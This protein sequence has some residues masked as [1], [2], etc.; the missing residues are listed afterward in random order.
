MY[1]CDN[2]VK[3]VHVCDDDDYSDDMMTMNLCGLCAMMIFSV[4]MCAI[5]MM[6]TLMIMLTMMMTMNVCLCVCDDYDDLM[7]MMTI[8]VCMCVL[9]MNMHIYIFS[10][11]GSS[12]GLV[13]TE[14]ERRSRLD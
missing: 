4:C 9:M 8:N 1:V 13:R 6:M 5:M 11:A 14:T 3:A 10:C 2:D 7:L 12:R